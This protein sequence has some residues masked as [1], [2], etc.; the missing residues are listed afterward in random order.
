MIGI[1]D[2]VLRESRGG[3]YLEMPD[4]MMKECIMGKWTSVGAD[5]PRPYISISISYTVLPQ[6]KKEK[7]IRSLLYASLSHF[8]ERKHGSN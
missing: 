8:P 1:L 7:E 4:Y 2:E 3:P 5:K 6:S